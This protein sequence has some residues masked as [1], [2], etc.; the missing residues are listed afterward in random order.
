MPQTSQIK[1]FAALNNQVLNANGRA[2][3]DEQEIRAKV[4]SCCFCQGEEVVYV[5][6]N[7]GHRVSASAAAH[8]QGGV[9]FAKRLLD[10]EL[11]PLGVSAE[12]RATILTSVLGQDP[13]VFRAG[14]SR[15][16][17]EAT[18]QI[19]ALRAYIGER[20]AGLINCALAHH[21]PFD[22]AGAVHLARAAVL[23]SLAPGLSDE[24]AFRHGALFGKLNPQLGP[25]LAAALVAATVA[26]GIG[27][28][29][30]DIDSAVALLQAVPTMTGAQ[31]LEMALDPFYGVFVQELVPRKAAELVALLKEKNISFEEAD[32]KDS[33]EQKLVA[34]AVRGMK[35]NAALSARDALQN[36]GHFTGPKVQASPEFLREPRVKGMTKV[37]ARDPKVLHIH[38]MRELAQAKPT[39]SS[40]VGIGM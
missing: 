32:K 6:Q 38:P 12:R 31:G 36:A 22:V 11:G 1:S 27:Q 15:R 7:P 16:L 18:A 14:H 30:A 21:L 29:S 26:R 40:S 20:A 2:A 5:K 25:V 8:K 17:A 9:G 3:A 23:L 37:Q 10:Q 24:Q 35:A 13:K 4:K 34:H 19:T 33:H 28:S 39:Q